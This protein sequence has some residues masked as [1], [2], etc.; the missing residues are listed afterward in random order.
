MEFT[1]KTIT[2]GDETWLLLIE[3]NTKINIEVPSA[4]YR[5]LVK[6]DRKKSK[7][8]NSREIIHLLYSCRLWFRSI[9]RWLSV[10]LARSVTEP[11]LSYESSFEM[12]YTTFPTIRNYAVSNINSVV[13]QT[14]QMRRF[15]SSPKCPH[16][17][18]VP[19][20]LLFNG[21]RGSSAGLIYMRRRDLE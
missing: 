10:C 19:Y 16:R 15:F 17:T 4:Q 14:K 6:K 18:G 7:Y 1:I 2:C 21:H 3:E 12:P 5:V 13:K 11:Q 20:N 8:G 9:L